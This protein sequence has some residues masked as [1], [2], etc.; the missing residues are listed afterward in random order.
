MEKVNSCQ[1]LIGFFIAFVG[2]GT[3][4]SNMT[5]FG[6][7]LGG[8]IGI[9]GVIIMALS[10]EKLRNPNWLRRQAKI[11]KNYLS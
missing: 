8:F 10:F 11:I 7:L 2:A 9:C 6:T 4:D 1:F 5:N 3:S